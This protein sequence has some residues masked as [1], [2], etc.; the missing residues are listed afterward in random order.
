MIILDPNWLLPPAYRPE[1]PPTP[2]PGRPFSSPPSGRMLSF[3]LSTHHQRSSFINSQ[4]LSTSGPPPHPKRRWT[5]FLRSYEVKHNRVSSLH[6]G[7]QEVG[8]EVGWGKDDPAPPPNGSNCF[9]ILSVT[10]QSH[11]SLY[12]HPNSNMFWTTIKLQSPLLNF[13]KF[14]NS[15]RR[16]YNRSLPCYCQAQMKF[17]T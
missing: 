15:L 16:S 14:S 4:R 9:M 11:C 8:E 5:P 10:F 17:I 7:R 3:L 2:C 6:I 1:S 12:P 13:S